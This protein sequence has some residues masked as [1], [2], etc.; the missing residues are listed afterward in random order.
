MTG[1]NLLTLL[2]GLLDFE[3]NGDAAYTQEEFDRIVSQLIDQNV[4]SGAP[5]PA[6]EEAIRRLPKKKIDK[7][8]L[9]PE[10]KAEC[11]ICMDAVEMG[12]EV[13]V[14]PCQHW[15]HP[16]CIE[17]WISQHNSCPQC[18]RPIDEQPP[19]GRRPSHRPSGGQ[20]GGEPRGRGG[21]WQRSTGQ[22]RQPQQEQQLPT[23]Q[24]QP[25]G[26]EQ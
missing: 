20:R 7:E 15:F 5:P 18:R 24:W 11:S 8:M 14:L 6:P 22:W 3:R 12:T 21:Q 25:V 9:G 1:P 16:G 17:I 23:G 19:S 2:S 26:Q 10:G 4:G 13:T